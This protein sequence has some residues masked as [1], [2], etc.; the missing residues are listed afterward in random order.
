MRRFRAQQFP[1]A[2]I[3]R[4]YTYFG[5]NLGAIFRISK[6]L[7]HIKWAPVTTAWCFAVADGGDGLQIWWVAANIWNTQSRTADKGHPL[8]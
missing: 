4:L 6:G 5:P 3:S 8:T 7:F 1:F 2:N